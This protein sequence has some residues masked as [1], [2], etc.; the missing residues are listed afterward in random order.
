MYAYDLTNF[1]MEYFREPKAPARK[2]Y[3]LRTP[4]P[5]AP[6][7][8]VLVVEHNHR[9]LITL[10]RET[11]DLVTETGSAAMLSDFTEA[12]DQALDYLRRH[13]AFIAELEQLI[14]TNPTAFEG[15]DMWTSL[16]ALGSVFAPRGGNYVQ[17]EDSTE[18][19]FRWNPES[20]AMTKYFRDH[21]RLRRY[22]PQLETFASISLRLEEFHISIQQDLYAVRTAAQKRLASVAGNP[23]AEAMLAEIEAALPTTEDYRA[24][25]QN[26]RNRADAYAY[27]IDR[28]VTA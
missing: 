10:L 27:A 23:A 26:R 19:A 12:R 15:H 7:D 25:D 14:A 3:Q 2:W 28:V 24:L 5:A 21:T 1:T 18:L 6:R 22:L 13:A 11:H 20:H 16:G 17:I 8:D 9:E 4:K